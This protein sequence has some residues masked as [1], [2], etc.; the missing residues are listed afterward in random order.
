MSGYYNKNGGY[1]G[2]PVSWA[3][4]T[5]TGGGIFPIDIS[6]FTPP[7]APSYSLVAATR[8]PFLGNFGAV[9]WP[10][11]GW[12]ILQN[13][14]IDDSWVQVTIPT[15]YFNSTAYTD[16]YI[17]SN[18]YITFGGGSGNFS[19]LS[20]VDPPYNK[21]M[22]QASD[23]SYQRVAYKTSANYTQIRYE[24]AAATS[25]TPGSPGI[26]YEATFFNSA[27]TGGVPWVEILIGSFSRTGGVS[28]IYTSSGTTLGTFNPAAN[29]SYVLRGNNAAGTSF[30]V[31]TGYC[32]NYI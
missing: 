2:N 17:G 20:A 16:A 25:G 31:Y 8:A 18:T 23:N 27:S 5:A 19:G 10:P 32:V 12:T 26:V 15:F 24:G 3:P 21:I 28:G 13:S 14:S 22:M 6:R 9:T 11:T 7:G 1:L 30:T 4:R 29:Q